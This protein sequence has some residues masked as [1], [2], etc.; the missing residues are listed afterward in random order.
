MF[1]DV[2][3]NERTRILVVAAHPDDE[4]LGC[5][6]T[7]ARAKARGASI[8]VLFLGEGISGRFP[9][10]QYDSDAFREQTEVRVDSARR[11]LEKLGI[12]DVTMGTRYCCQFD[13]IPLIQFTQ[14]I[15]SHIERFRPTLILTHNSAEVNVDHSTTFQ[16]VENACRPTVAWTPKNIL[17]F[18]IV[19]SG[20]WTLDTV[21]KPNL[22]VDISEFWDQ[23]MEAWHCYAAEARPFPF[24][25][26]DTGLETLARFRGMQAGLEKAEAFRV[27]RAIV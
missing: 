22:Y 7:L 13:T 4:V 23:K 12:D 5:G 19:C 20:N 1:T 11:A 2:D 25:R 15:E 17:C 6:G 21:F 24:P 10:G 14:E 3:F 9:L 18:E 27:L 8:A 26:S 16:A